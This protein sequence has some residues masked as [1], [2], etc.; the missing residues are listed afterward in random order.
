MG[1]DPPG[2]A[3]VP[4]ACTPVPSRSVSLRFSTRPPSRP[5]RYGPGRSRVL[6]PLPVETGGGNEP[7]CAKSCAGETPALPGG[8]HPLTPSHQMCSIGIRVHSWFLINDPPQLLPP[9]IRPAGLRPL[10]EQEGWEE[11]P[12]GSAGVPPA[13]APVPCRSVSLRFST[14]PPCRPARHGPGRS[15]VLA[16]LPVEPGGGNEPG[17]AK[18]CAGGTPALLGGLHPLAPSH[19]MCSIGIRVDSCSFVVQSH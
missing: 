4:P 19:Q 6:A 13:F 2:S 9:M 8:L 14:R 3:G 17:C 5:A 7:G 1:I 10:E 11:D 16:P 12:P 18:S 15:E